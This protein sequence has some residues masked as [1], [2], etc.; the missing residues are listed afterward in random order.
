MTGTTPE[1]RARANIDRL[2]E[3][4]G[5]S[6]QGV[7]ALN[8]FASRGVAVREFPLRH[9]HG[10]ADYLLYVDGRAAGVVE[11]KPAGHTLTGVESQ[12]GNM[13]TDCLTLCPITSD[14]AVPVRQHWR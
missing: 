8:P 2:L 9:G 3:Q 12:S 4:A 7:V 6:L 10:F 1:Q 14:P 13:A 5:W 11:A